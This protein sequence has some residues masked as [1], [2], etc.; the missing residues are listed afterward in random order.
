[1]SIFRSVSVVVA[2]LVMAFALAEQAS[3]KPAR[4][5]TTD[6]GHYPCDFKALDT[7]GSFEVSAQG[8][9]TYTLQVY[10]IG[11]ASALVNL[12]SGNV[13]LPGIYVRLDREP[14]CWES[15]ELRTRICAW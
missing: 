11:M 9:P 2:T 14:A 15:R 1:M 4:C 5:F 13:S 10:E 8:K 7:S 12:G 3:A 6:D